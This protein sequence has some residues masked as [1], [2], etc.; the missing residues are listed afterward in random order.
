MSLIIE[1]S[2]VGQ[3]LIASPK[4]R[5]K[6]EKKIM[7][8][9][10]NTNEIT[11]TIVLN[12]NLY[13]KVLI[14]R[15]KQKTK[16]IFWGGYTMSNSF[17]VLHSSKEEFTNT[18][19]LNNN[20]SMSP[21][22][23][24]KLFVERGFKLKH[25]LVVSGYCSWNTKDIEKQIIYDY[26]LLSNKKETIQDITNKSNIKWRNYINENKTHSYNFSQEFYS[27]MS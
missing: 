17:L 5:G 22:K 8:C 13:E 18:V 21:L 16:A 15:H 25:Y 9:C 10:E 2:L 4:I 11:T 3:I 26:W 14:D 1:G 20:F 7:I 24:V 27:T 19:R 23:D 6:L 12:E